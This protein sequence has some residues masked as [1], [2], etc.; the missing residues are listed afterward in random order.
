MTCKETLKTVTISAEFTFKKV[1]STDIICFSDQMDS[2]S[3]NCENE[4]KRSSVYVDNTQCTVS[5]RA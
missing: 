4:Q 3:S 5:E 2:L 1:K